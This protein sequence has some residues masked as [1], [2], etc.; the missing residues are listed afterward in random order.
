MNGGER[1]LAAALGAV[2]L[3][4]RAV[5]FV[6][7]RF[8]SDEPQHLHVAWGWTAGLL[9]YRDFFDNHAPLFHML[10][11]PLLRLAGER[12]DVLLFMRVPMLVLWA[13]V[14]VSSFY[15]ARRMY[16]TRVAV[17]STLLLNA[18]PPFF[19]KS[20]EFRTDNLWN[21][22][23]MA[24]VATLPR[25]PLLAGFLL[26]CALCV[27]LKTSLLLF[28]IGGA[29]VVTVWMRGTP[30]RARWAVALAAGVVVMPSIVAAYFVSRGAW[31]NLVYC[32]FTFNELVGKM[33]PPLLIWIP[34]LL[35]LPL[36]VIALRIAWR[37]R[38]ATTDRRFFYAIATTL[39]FLTLFGFWLLI[40]PRDFLP[41]LPIFSIYVAAMMLRARRLGASAPG[42]AGL[43]A[44]CLIA[45][46]YYAG[47]FRNQTREFITQESQLLRLTRPGEPVMD[48][49]G[50]LIFRPRAS[51]YILEFI[52]RNAILRGLLRDTIAED[53][54]RARCHVAQADG[55][56]WPDGARS[57][58]AANF[59]NVGRLRVSGQFLRPDGSFDIAVPGDYVIVDRNGIVA[60]S[61]TYA[62]GHY[63]FPQ[64]ARGSRLAVFWSPAFARGFTPFRFQDL[65]F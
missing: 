43:V 9:Q 5:A 55:A 13:A 36:V 16:D 34:R 26:G 64:A 10:M 23:W 56:Q 1:R 35:W 45:T 20:L 33:R 28:T 65:D 21:A 59:L 3:A 41:F 61:R 58:L 54:V 53:V 2:T 19:L 32:V 63:S 62:A 30:V 38:D 25:F 52:T 40:S 14:T 6:H 49:K 4:M 24:A 17:W 48:Y 39:F 22:C 42:V 27:S 44:V 60:P 46:T 47:G 15:L 12:A 29:T 11:A 50:E 8:D 18:F 51:Y 7:Y 31:H 37:Y 57:F